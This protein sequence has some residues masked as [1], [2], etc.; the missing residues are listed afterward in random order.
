[1]SAHH[2]TK[3]LG[4]CLLLCPLST[5]I[6]NEKGDRPRPNPVTLFAWGLLD[7]NPQDQNVRETSVGGFHPAELIWVSTGMT[8]A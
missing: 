8:Q 5:L 7:T 3:Y 2:T 1:M 6:Q 4:A